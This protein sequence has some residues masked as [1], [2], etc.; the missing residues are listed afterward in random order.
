MLISN[1]EEIK[2]YIVEHLSNIT[3][4][5]LSVVFLFK[6]LAAGIMAD[7]MLKKTL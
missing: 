3:K 7:K 6:V 2:N 4:F 1:F 5:F